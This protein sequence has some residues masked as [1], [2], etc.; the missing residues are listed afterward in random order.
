MV[1][2]CRNYKIVSI[3]TR[4]YKNNDENNCYTEYKKDII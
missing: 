2:E 3:I 4:I 1:I